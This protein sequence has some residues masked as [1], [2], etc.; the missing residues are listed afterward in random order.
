M[1][2]ALTLEDLER[3]AAAAGFAMAGIDDLSD[4]HPR[5]APKAQ[6]AEDVARGARAPKVA[7]PALT[8]PHAATD[9]NGKGRLA[10]GAQAVRESVYGYLRFGIP[11]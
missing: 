6:A 3:A 4:A 8:S 7:L 10:S 9:A 2:T 5:N 1:G 11:A